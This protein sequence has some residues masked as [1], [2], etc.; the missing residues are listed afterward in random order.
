MALI[1][2]AQGARQFDLG[3]I[4][5]RDMRLCRFLRGLLLWHTCW[6]LFIQEGG[7]VRVYRPILWTSFE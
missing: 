1:V 3:A 2:F 7:C 4:F 5:L 6:F